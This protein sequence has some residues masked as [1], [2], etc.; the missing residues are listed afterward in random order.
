[1]YFNDVKK[2]IGENRPGKK[3]VQVF[4]AVSKILEKLHSIN[5]IEIS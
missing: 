2:K 4:Q 1:M 3:N 5:I